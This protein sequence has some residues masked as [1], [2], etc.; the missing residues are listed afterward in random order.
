MS[1]G[2]PCEHSEKMA[3]RQAR[4]KV[5]EKAEMLTPWS[6]NSNDPNEENDFPWGLPMLQVTYCIC[7]AK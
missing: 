1:G 5:S 6:W 4:R 3:M 2:Q 7:L